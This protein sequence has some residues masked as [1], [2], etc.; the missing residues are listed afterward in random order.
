MCLLLTLLT[1]LC[2]PVTLVCRAMNQIF[3]CGLV[4]WRTVLTVLWTRVT[5]GDPRLCLVFFARRALLCPSHTRRRSVDFRAARQ[6]R[7]QILLLRPVCGVCAAQQLV[8][9]VFASASETHDAWNW[10]YPIFDAWRLVLTNQSKSRAW[11]A[12]ASDRNIKKK[13][14]CLLSTKTMFST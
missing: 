10:A 2:L 7:Y 11:A 8:S 14:K 9:S 12:P 1:C 3:A 13:K 6:R 5:V 4:N